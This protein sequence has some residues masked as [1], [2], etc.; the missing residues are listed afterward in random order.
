[1][2]TSA[3]R[4]PG[5]VAVVALVAGLGIS[6]SR[7]EVAALLTDGGQFIRT[8]IRLV[9]RGRLTSVWQTS[10]RTRADQRIQRVTL[11]ESGAARGDGVPS[12]AVN[13]LTRLPWAVWSFN[14]NGDAELA[15]SLFDGTRWSSPILLGSE[16]NGAADLQPQ[17]LFT[18]TGRP[19]ITWWRLSAD[20]TQQSVWLTARSNGTWLQPVRLS[21][22]RVRASRP[23]LLLRDSD[24]IVAFDSDSGVQ[25]RTLPAESTALGGT[26]T[27][28]GLE[29]PDPPTHS[30][31]RPPECQFIGCDGN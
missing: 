10:S 2:R 16:A 5:L 15:V 25:I 22:A 7:A 13:P 24:L 26:G 1:M 6:V 9:H 21:G 17:M 14:E 11:N 27:S 20:G 4:L 18:A 12:I 3:R 23:T 29:G 19:I 31:S 30:D 8:E 28:G